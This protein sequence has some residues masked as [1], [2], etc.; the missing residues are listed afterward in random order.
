V[1]FCGFLWIFGFF[2]FH[3]ARSNGIVNPV[4]I[5]VGSFGTRPPVLF[6]LEQIKEQELVEGI[7]DGPVLS[8]AFIFFRC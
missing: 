2:V 7:G 3:A 6:W 5:L 1:D 4:K 8:L